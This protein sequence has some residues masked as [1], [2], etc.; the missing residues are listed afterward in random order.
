M[1]MNPNVAND[2]LTAPLASPSGQFC[3]HRNIKNL[4]SILPWYSLSPFIP[5]FSSS[6]QMLYLSHYWQCYI[7]SFQLVFTSTSKFETFFFF[8]KS[9]RKSDFMRLITQEG[10]KGLLLMQIWCYIGHAQ[11]LLRFHKTASAAS[12]FTCSVIDTFLIFFSRTTECLFLFGQ[13]LVNSSVAN[14]TK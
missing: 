10:L 4:L 11:H 14:K 2:L 8:W 9:S 1:W 5:H 6:G 13:F 12:N 3:V 7:R